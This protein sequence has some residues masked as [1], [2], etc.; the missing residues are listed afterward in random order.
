M[1]DRD[2]KAKI[3]EKRSL[4]PVDG[5]FEAIFNTAIATQMVF[6]QPAKIGRHH[7]MAVLP[8]HRN[9]TATLFSFLPPAV[10]RSPVWP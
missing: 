6:Q 8:D 10:L 5:H 3:T 4:H 1:C 9:I 2:Y 7:A